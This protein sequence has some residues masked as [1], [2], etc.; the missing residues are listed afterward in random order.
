M[1]GS[2]T[3]CNFDSVFFD[4]W[5]RNCSMKLT[6]QILLEDLRRGR[7]F[8]LHNGKRLPKEYWEMADLRPDPVTYFHTQIWVD[9]VLEEGEVH[10]SEPEATPLVV[11]V[12][13][14]ER[15]KPFGQ[16]HHA[17]DPA[18]PDA[19]DQAAP[20]AKRESWTAA[21]FRG[22]PRQP[23]EKPAHYLHRVEKTVPGNIKKKFRVYDALKK[24]LQRS[25]KKSR[26][27][28]ESVSPKSQRRNPCKS[29]GSCVL[30][31]E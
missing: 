23:G 11:Q 21:A 3:L 9:G 15:V 29:A 22:P 5:Q 27:I 24:A 14:L 20:V 28:T 13:N 4:L 31:T 30:G 1:V 16:P 17:S 2:E 18:A 7:R 10:V 26:D 19:S 25:S 12:G 6:Y 8:A